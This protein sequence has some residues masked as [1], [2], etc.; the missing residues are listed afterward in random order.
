MDDLTEDDRWRLQMEARLFAL[1]KTV[2]I[3]IAASGQRGATA[4]ELGRTVEE[5]RE[6]TSG[7]EFEE[8]IIQAF[9]DIQAELLEEPDA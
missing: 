8:F 1:Q 3:L 7:S 9:Q 5:G 4:E 2:L 6:T